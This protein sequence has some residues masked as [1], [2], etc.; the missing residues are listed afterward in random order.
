MATW[1]STASLDALLNDI[2]NKATTVHLLDT[3]S[4]GQDYATVV[5]NSIG[6]AAITGTDFTGPQASG[7]NRELV[8]DGK[9]GMATANSSVGQL[10]IAI[11]SGSEVLC[12]TDETSD[13]PI[14]SGNPLV[15]PS[16]S[17]FS[18]QPTQI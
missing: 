13:Q 5:G 6:S 11:T 16:F 12:V 18:M 3:Y 9:S 7:N 17:M 2:K 15:F 8:F 14:T 4:A 1:Y 10:H